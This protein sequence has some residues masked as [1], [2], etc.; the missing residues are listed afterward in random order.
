MRPVKRYVLGGVAIA[1][2][3]AVGVVT[4]VRPIHAQNQPAPVTHESSATFRKV[5]KKTLPAVVSI[6][7]KA[8][9]TKVADGG[10]RERLQEEL[11]RR[12]GG[13]LPPNFRRFFEMIPDEDGDG[14]GFQPRR[15]VV[16]HGSGVIIAADGTIV[17]NNH[18]VRGADSVEVRL[19][20]GRT[21]ETTNIVRDPKTD[22]AVV[23]LK[24]EDASNLPVAEL[25][26]S[27]Q[28]EIGDWV[29]AMGSPFGLNGSVTAGIVSAKGRPGHGLGIMYA[30]FIQT[31]AAINPGN[32]GGPI[33]NLDGQV[34][35]IN[36]AIRS[37]TGTNGGVGFSIP[38]NMVK[39]IVDQLVKNGK[40]RRG[41]LGVR[42]ADASPEVLRK[43]NLKEGVLVMA[44]TPGQTPASKAGLQPT[45]VILEIDGFKI[46]SSKSLQQYVTRAEIGKKLNFKI[47]RSG[48]TITVP[49]QIE[50]QP[51]NYGVETLVG[52]EPKEL[53]EPAATSI[54]K[55][56]VKV[57]KLG[58]EKGVTVT[59]VTPGSPADRAGISKG[60][61]ILQVENQ[62]VRS[63]EELTKAF[64]AGY[65]KDGVLLRV[66]HP[67]GSLALLVAKE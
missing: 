19:H 50:E 62:D 21:F 44:L 59:E 31:D 32:S 43:L 45:D 61:V 26:D 58:R 29:L 6:E 60:C 16:G 28:T 41:Y 14:E 4:S 2:L 52:A 65:P 22:L 63:A 12:F 25:G 34:V 20:D 47:V 38:S 1:S 39:D 53:E 48:K 33:V 54:E 66:R 36:T 23:R 46:D 57:E 35:G 3:A 67:D 18:V 17:T 24:K 15:P 13:Q 37:T 30:D 55:L 11:K 42:M 9:A 27:N 8:S 10:Q 56:G 64:S 49:V 7:T 51:E 5:V 40:V